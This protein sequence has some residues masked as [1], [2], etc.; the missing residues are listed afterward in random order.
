M[1]FDDRH[2]AGRQLAQKLLE[3]HPPH[4]V[5]LAIPRG[6]VPV[7]F[8]IAGALHAPLDLVLVR[9]I[10][11]PFQQELAIGA[12]AD[13]PE[14]ELVTDSRLIA[15]LGVSNNYLEET[16][17]AALAEIERRRQTYL[18]DRAPC[19]ISGHTAIVV[20]DGVA[21]G[22]TTLAALRATRRRHPSRIVLAV[23]VA[24]RAFLRRVRREVDDVICLHAP[25]D[26]IAV[27]L[28]Y[29]DFRQLQDQEVILLLQQAQHCAAPELREPPP[30]PRPAR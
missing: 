25:A 16:K 23:P 21:T 3:S 19:P 8:E 4:P 10:G 13:G 29:R 28:F 26:L 22:S 6:G 12:I 18:A 30:S 27:G 14:P 20:D 2:D 7:G 24:A 11:A 1:Q 9:K 5:V 15:A 17:T